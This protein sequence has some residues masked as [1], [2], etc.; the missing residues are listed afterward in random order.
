MVDKAGFK[1]HVYN[2][3]SGNKEKKADVAIATA[4]MDG[5]STSSTR[6]TTI[7]CW[8]PRQKQTKELRRTCRLRAQ[9]RKPAFLC[10]SLR[11]PQRAFKKNDIAVDSF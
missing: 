10:S 3:N 8:L 11:P 2:K 9:K 7:S 1:T 5:R 4:M 6:T